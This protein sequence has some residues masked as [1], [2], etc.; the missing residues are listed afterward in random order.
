MEIF[1]LADS[2]KS[3]KQNN[4]RAPK[5]LGHFELSFDDG[6]E[7]TDIKQA[8]KDQNRANI[9]VNGKFEFSLDLAQVVEF[10]IKVGKKIS[11][12]E[13][14]KFRSAS[15]FGILYQRT[16]EWVLS[17]PH[18]I[19]E[20]RDYLKRKRAKRISE[21]KVA[22][23]NRERSK[24]DRIKYKLR[25]KELPI[26]SDEEIDMVIKRL[27]EHGFLDDEKFAKYYV[28]N[29]NV[30]KGISQ[31]KLEQ[32]LRQKG[33]DSDIIE[34]ALSSSSRTSDDEMQKIIDR[35]RNKYTDEKLIAYLVRQGFEYQRAKAAVL[36][37]D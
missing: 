18:S 23:S 36:E 22:V 3:K 1:S 26:F 29:R 4:A 30:K 37:T 8:V 25:T 13:L 15:Q 21:N 6:Y 2:P 9:F 24:E 16:L 20:T 5:S 28:E 12:D 11:Q 14:G 10:K 27:S 31:R 35:K 7:V 19:F 33:L 32:E 17:R 34:L